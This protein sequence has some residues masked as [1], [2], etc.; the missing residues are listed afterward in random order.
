MKIPEQLLLSDLLRHR[1]RCDLGIE[2]GPGILVW[3]HP[4]VHRILGWASRPSTLNVSRTVWRL[5][6]IR[7]I[8]DLEVFVK[9]E[10]AKSDLITLERLP[11]L[12]NAD[13][14]NS[15]GVHIG[16]IAD[17][18]FNPLTGKIN[19]Y[20]VS[21]S[22]PRIPGTSRWRLAIDI[23]VDQ[24][25]GM[26]SANINSLEDLPLSKSSIRQNFLT[27][28]RE[29]KEHFYEV[30]QKATNKLEG[31]IEDQNI[32]ENYEQ[33][34]IANKENLYDDW[35]DEFADQRNNTKVEYNNS[36]D[37]PSQFTK[38]SHSKDDPWI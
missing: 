14:L 26:V 12:V 18:I 29:W 33:D 27:K 9:G 16:R 24:Q 10:P 32:E 4:P 8:G 38:T 28:S 15:S 35:V 21:R 20:L 2:H 17:F 36:E 25:P 3:M 11:T 37:L 31:W 1:V 34:Y 30:K 19:Y 7:A 22:D 13:F 6:Q 23:I 5:D